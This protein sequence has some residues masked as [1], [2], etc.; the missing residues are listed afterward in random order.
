MFY[1]LKID[2]TNC[3]NG[4]DASF[5]MKVIDNNAYHDGIIYIYD[6]DLV[7]E[8]CKPYSI[9]AFKPGDKVHKSRDEDSSEEWTI[10]AIV[11]ATYGLMN[12]YIVDADGNKEISY[13]GD[14][15][16]INK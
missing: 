15:V 12:V 1:M 11:P 5:I 16:L 8:G 4:V 14:L 10:E 3:K 9:T 7:D 6:N 2:T 13:S